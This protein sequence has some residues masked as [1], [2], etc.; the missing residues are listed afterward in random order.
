MYTRKIPM[1]IQF[2]FCK[3]FGTYKVHYSVGLLVF[4][5]FTLSGFKFDIVESSTMTRVIYGFA[6]VFSLVFC[7]S[8][9]KEIFQKIKFFRQNRIINHFM[10][11]ILATSIS[12]KFDYFFIQLFEFIDPSCRF[13]ISLMQDNPLFKYFKFYSLNFPAEL[14]Y[15]VVFWP[16][17]ELIDSYLNKK[18]QVLKMMRNDA[19]Y[20][21]EELPFLKEVPKNSRKDIIAIEAQQNY[22]KLIYPQRNYLVLYRFKDALELLPQELGMKIHRSYW[23]AFHG[24]DKI[25]SSSKVILI[26]GLEIPISRSYSISLKMKHAEKP[27]YISNF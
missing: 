19:K 10:V 16:L 2:N 5:S 23:V 13:D 17:C 26:N 21:F 3:Y 14:K 9:T 8:F 24:I 20:S 12:V 25:I 22:I 1:F 15:S 4:L 7:L 6:Q 27:Y 18:N 11:I